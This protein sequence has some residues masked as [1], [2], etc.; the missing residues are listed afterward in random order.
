MGRHVADNKPVDQ[1]NEAARESARTA[2][3]Q[4]GIQPRT[5]ADV[6]L[7][8][9]LGSNETHCRDPRCPDTNWGGHD[10]RHT[11][12][13]DCPPADGSYW[14]RPAR[15]PLPGTPLAPT[16][17]RTPTAAPNPAPARKPL[18]QPTSDKKWCQDPHCRHTNWG[19]RDRRHTRGSDC[20][21][22]PTTTA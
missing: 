17:T 1:T 16:G 15:K 20:P 7:E 4:F 5:E 19:G 11:R 2:G 18:T 12:G 9:R 14:K 22:L 3:G 21:P 10:R 13:G 6:E 8:P